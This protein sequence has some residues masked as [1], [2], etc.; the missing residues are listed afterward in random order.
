MSG[1]AGVIYL[2]GMLVDETLIR[3]MTEVI[4]HRGPDEAGQWVN[5]SVGLGHR[6]LRTTPESLGEH[7]PVVSQA[8]ELVLVADARIDNRDELI[9]LLGLG[10]QRGNAASD[11]DL[12]LAAYQKW[13][14]QSGEK[15]LG[16]FAFAIWDGRKQSLFC[17]RDHFGV[18]P[19]VYHYAPG[20]VFVFGSETKVVLCLPDFP[21]RLNELKLGYHLSLTIFDQKCTIYEEAFRKVFTEAVRCRLRS[22]FP[23][24]STL[25]GGGLLR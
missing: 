4:E 13:G 3:R 24:A 22:A 21:D 5:G 8:G 7:Q 18:K 2:N 1:I 10:V 16:D 9:S 20:Q 25:S 14:E 11:S 15:L 17:A 6:M 23:V 19:F 12:I